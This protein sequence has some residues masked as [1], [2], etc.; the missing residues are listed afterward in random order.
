MPK[1]LSWGSTDPWREAAGLDCLPHGDG[2]TGGP[3][4]THETCLWW[5]GRD[6][7]VTLISRVG[8]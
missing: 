5:E 6:S 3:K 2:V 8:T 7:A 1:W 4:H